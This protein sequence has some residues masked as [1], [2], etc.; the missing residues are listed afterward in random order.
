MTGIWAAP[1]VRRAMSE[2]EASRPT[3]LELFYDLVFVAVFIQVGDRLSQD[4][5]WLGVGQVLVLFIPLWW[6]WANFTWYMNQFQADDVW[7]RLL[8][9][10][11]MFLV[12]WM[13]LSVPGA[14]EDSST[15]FV[16]CVI[17]FRLTMIAM[18]LRTLRHAPDDRPLLMFYVWRYH[19]VGAAAWGLSLLLPP[20]QRWW[21]WT[22]VFLWELYNSNSR[23]LAAHLSRFP[24]HLGHLAERYGTL[25]IL[26]LGESFIKSVTVSP[27]PPMTV[28]AVLYSL[29]GVLLVFALW[30][31]YFNDVHERGH[32]HLRPGAA[33]SWLHLHLPLSLALVSFGVA[34]KKMFEGTVSHHLEPSYVALFLGSLALFGL[35]LALVAPNR[36]LATTLW[37]VG[38]AAVLV[39]LI[40]LAVS[41]HWSATAIM[42]AGSTVMG[43]QVVREVWAAR[44]ETGPDLAPRE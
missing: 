3:W 13:G 40:P 2:E 25:V 21:V 20:D 38:G 34:K 17:G 39:A 5:S 23:A 28:G 9:V 35:L 33:V 26:V 10:L 27:S 14:F 44:A 7:H 41:A 36:T 42:L 29:P 24:V 6:V 16:L 18:Y 22:A 32:G 30:W 15:Q 43:A 19:V 37:R 4:V 1:R 8:L 11:Q 12:A 31:L